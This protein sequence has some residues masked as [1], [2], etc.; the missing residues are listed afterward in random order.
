MGLGI[1]T[2]CLKATA[3]DHCHCALS[4]S[5][6]SNHHYQ[7]MTADSQLSGHLVVDALVQVNILLCRVPKLTDASK[8][9]H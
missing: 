1:G 5:A 3:G 9:V 8:G 6:H 7:T 2:I 4:L